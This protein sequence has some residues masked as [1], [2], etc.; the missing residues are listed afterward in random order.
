MS[1]WQGDANKT[2]AAFTRGRGWSVGVTVNGHGAYVLVKTI[3]ERIAQK[4]G[5]R[6]LSY[7]DDHAGRFCCS[8]KIPT[9][10]SD[11]C[12]TTYGLWKPLFAIGAAEWVKIGRVSV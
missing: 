10:C 3:A 11:Y 5:Y 9:S 6:Q 1:F 7:V 8:A 4:T 2:G 12:R